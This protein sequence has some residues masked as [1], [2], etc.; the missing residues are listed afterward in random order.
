MPVAQHASQQRPVP[1]GVP[2][3]QAL[4]HLA[5]GVLETGFEARRQV[6]GGHPL[7]LLAD[8]P[9]AYPPVTIDE[10]PEHAGQHR[11]IHG[12]TLMESVAGNQGQ[13]TAQ[14]A[15][16]ILTS[17]NQ[18]GS[19]IFA[20]RARNLESLRRGSSITSTLI[21]ASS[22]GSWSCANCSHWNARSLSPSAA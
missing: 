11:R 6:R 9:M 7:H 15:S 14:K 13:W 8:G 19:R 1:E 22:L 4:V 17:G 12:Q 16:A 18:G 10:R 21:T 2:L 5:L 20:S 3:E